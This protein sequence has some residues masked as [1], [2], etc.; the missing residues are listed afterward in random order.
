MKLQQAI[1]VYIQKYG[2]MGLA[3]FIGIPLPGSGV[4]SAA[5]G[6]Y[7]LGFKFKDYLVA[8]ILGVLIAGIIVMLVSTAGNEAWMFLIKRV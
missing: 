3:L 6:A 2:I 4:Y 8:T 1:Q 5:L 7:V